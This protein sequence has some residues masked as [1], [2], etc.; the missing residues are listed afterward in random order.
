MN[1]ILGV[2]EV[3]RQRRLCEANGYDQVVV[4][5]DSHE[6]LRAERDRFAVEAARAMSNL[7][8]HER[9]QAED[10]A[11]MADQFYRMMWERD[12]AVRLFRLA[13]KA[14]RMLRRGES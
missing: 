11:A 6:A 4:L 13:N 5:A 3:A 9:H 10:D 2:E 1:E 8:D 7:N 14:K 12:R